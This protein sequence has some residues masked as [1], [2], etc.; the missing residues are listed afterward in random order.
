MR[1]QSFSLMPWKGT[2]SSYDGKVTISSGSPQYCKVTSG[3]IEYSLSI[4]EPDFSF[5]DAMS[6][7]ITRY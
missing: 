5:L 3:L 2:A 6:L 1:K 4:S 7:G